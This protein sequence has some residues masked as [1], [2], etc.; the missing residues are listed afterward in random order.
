[1]DKARDRR[2]R[3]TAVAQ[4]AVADAGELLRGG[5]VAVLCYVLVITAGFGMLIRPAVIP[6]IRKLVNE[7]RR[8]A[9]RRLGRPVPRPYRPFTGRWDKDIATMLTD[10]AT[11]RDLAWLVAQAVLGFSLTVI[12]VSLWAGALAGPFIPLIRALTPP[13]NTLD[14]GPFPVTSLPVAFAVIPFGI[15]LGVLAFWLCRWAPW[16]QARLGARLLAP[17]ERAM[18]AAR[19][20]RLHETRT[21]AVDAR[22]TE[23]RRIER[24]LHDGAQARLVSL[25]MNLGMAEEEITEHPEMARRLVAEA[26]DSAGKALSEL[27][28]LVRGIHPPV[29]ADR[30]LAGGIEALALA[31]AAPVQ[32]DIQLRRRLVAPVESALY[33]VV[34]EALANIAKHADASWAFIRLWEDDHDRIRLLIHDDG[35]G[36]ANPEGGSGLRGIERRLAVFDGQLTVKSPQGGPTELFIEL[37]CQQ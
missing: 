22:A 2:R 3:G 8:H 6:L 19:V 35:R 31:S 12:G 37:H 5:V 23:L 1:M 34:A 7:E 21:E 20:A 16:L 10:P 18:L 9:E 13:A 17:T 14:Y 27:R 33:F 4:H 32:V 36:G 15:L 25:A 30:G 24:D 29:L 26:R 28:D 11:W